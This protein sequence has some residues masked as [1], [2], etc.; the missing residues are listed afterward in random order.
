MVVA[1]VVGPICESSDFLAQDRYMPNVKQGQ[2]LAVMSAGAYSF[3]MSSNYCSRPRIAEVMVKEDAFNV[4][5]TRES[6]EDLI[7]R[8]TIPLFL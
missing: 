3:S 2:L 8:E 1:D 7:S 5:R 6:H 4:V